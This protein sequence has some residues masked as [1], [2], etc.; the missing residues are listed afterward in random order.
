MSLCSTR[1]IG[2]KDAATATLIAADFG[3]QVESAQN[4]GDDPVHARAAEV[5]TGLGGA[6]LVGTVAWGQLCAGARQD[7]I[8]LLGE[9]P[10]AVSRAKEAA[11]EPCG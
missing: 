9:K 5:L 1:T 2:P 4:E 3:Y 6:A 11:G 8:D 7:R 10:V